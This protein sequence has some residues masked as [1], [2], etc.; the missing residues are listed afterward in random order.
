MSDWRRP[1]QDRYMSSCYFQAM[2][3]YSSTLSLSVLSLL[4]CLS[5]CSCA[6]VCILW[7]CLWWIWAQPMK[8]TFI[9]LS[10][11]LSFSLSVSLY[12]CAC[13]CASSITV[14]VMGPDSSQWKWQVEDIVFDRSFFFLRSSVFHALVNLWLVHRS[15][16]QGTS[17]DQVK[18]LNET[19]FIFLCFWGWCGAWKSQQ[20]LVG[21]NNR[22][23]VELQRG[24]RQEIVGRIHTGKVPI[25]K[26]LQV[27]QL[28]SLYDFLCYVS[29]HVLYSWALA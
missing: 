4:V 20:E 23:E 6:C 27:C 3:K 16:Y 28:G 18:N 26:E 22:H 1:T 2:Q 25:R 15:S 19:L 5:V 9:L 29:C 11:S 14:P 12:S 10:F 7:L 17:I 24:E 13:M 21:P 8:M